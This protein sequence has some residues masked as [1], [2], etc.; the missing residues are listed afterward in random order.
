MFPRLGRLV[1]NVSDSPS[2]R[3]AAAI[4]SVIVFGV[5]E[6]ATHRGLAQLELPPFADAVMDA[7][8]VGLSFGLAVWALLVGNCER[9]TRVRR[10]LERISELNHEIRNALQVIAHSHFD[11]DAAHRQMVMDS[12]ARIDAV[13]KRVFPVVGGQQK[14]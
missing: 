6:F 12:V 2:Y 8:L 3:Y 7:G 5:I 13:L 4:F 11:A 1:G 10:D 14:R 9:R